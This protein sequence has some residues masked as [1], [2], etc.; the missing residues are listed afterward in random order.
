MPIVSRSRKRKGGPSSGGWVTLASHGFED[1]GLGPFYDPWAGDGRNVVMDDDTGLF[2]GKV[3]RTQY[4]ITSANSYDN[5]KGIAFS[6]GADASKCTT[7]GERGRMQGDFLIPL[8]STANRMRKLFYLFP[9]STAANGYQVLGEDTTWMYYGGV[10][11]NG[12]DIRVPVENTVPISKGVKHTLAM[13]WLLNSAYNVAD[14][15][16]KAYLNGDLKYTWANKILL[17][18][19]GS[20]GGLPDRYNEYGFGWQL[21]GDAD[22]GEYRYWDN[23]L[24]QKWVP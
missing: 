19:S 18:G 15:W 13:E 21:Q 3:L 12:A 20:Y 10:M 5:D 8:G 1:G 14:G 9:A 6:G 11:D 22:D 16:A 7:Y 24:V 2:G 17:K 23:L 4:I